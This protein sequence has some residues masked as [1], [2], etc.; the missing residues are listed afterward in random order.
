VTPQIGGMRQFSAL[1]IVERKEAMTATM[2]KCGTDGAEMRPF[3]W[4]IWRSPNLRRKM[5]APRNDWYANCSL[6]N[7]TNNDLFEG[8]R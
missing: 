5:R 8:R 6:P 1:T 4:E 2:T 3:Y 7:A